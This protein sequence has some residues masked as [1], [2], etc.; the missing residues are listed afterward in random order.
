MKHFKYILYGIVLSA[1]SSAYAGSYEDFFV[2]IKSDNASLIEG[3]L[4]RGFD[5]NTRD[6]KGQPGLTMAM[7]ERSAKTAKLLLG[8]RDIDVNALNQAGE[9]ALMLAALKGDLAG[10]QLLAQRGASIN[11]PGWSPLHYAATGPEPKLVAWLLERGAAI[12]AE[13][14]NGTTPLMMAAQYGSDD[15]VRLLLERGADASRRNQKGLRAV[16]F[17]KL[18]GRQP[19]V[20]RLEQAT[21]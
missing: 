10:A 1:V 12:D 14:P 3:L 7:Q 17:A 6:P 5:P 2:A 20:A 11:Q 4:Q 8:Q 16:D 15:S 13:S 19:V 9:S 18:S 21:R